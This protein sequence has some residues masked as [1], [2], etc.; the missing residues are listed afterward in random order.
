MIIIRRYAVTIYGISG[1]VLWGLNNATSTSYDASGLQWFLYWITSIFTLPFALVI[2]T[3][4]L[5]SKG[6][7]SPP[8]TVIVIVIGLMICACVDLTRFLIN[9]RTRLRSMGAKNPDQ[10]CRR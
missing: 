7:A 1:L 6:E 8:S 2:Q 10:S 3:P 5:L 9:R 4:I